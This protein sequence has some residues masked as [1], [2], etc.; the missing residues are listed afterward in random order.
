MDMKPKE[1]RRG[2][3]MGACRCDAAWRGETGMEAVTL[4]GVLAEVCPGPARLARGGA[5][6]V[7]Q[8]ASQRQRYTTAERLYT[9]HSKRKRPK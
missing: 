3:C 8:A 4:T 7:E 6:G 2:A 5:Q 9:E 1:E